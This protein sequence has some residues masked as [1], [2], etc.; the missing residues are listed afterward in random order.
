MLTTPIRAALGFG[1]GVVL[2]AFAFAAM[3]LGH[4]T[5]TPAIANVSFLAFV[6][7]LG[8]AIAT[9]GPPFLWGLYFVLI[10]KIA[11]PITRIVV[12]ALLALL[13]FR[14]SSPGGL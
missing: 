13:H 11:S 12:L 8:F 7:V 5:F 14:S 9:F 2:A 4:G 10:P 3:N 6:P 1:V